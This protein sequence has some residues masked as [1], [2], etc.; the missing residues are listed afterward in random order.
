MININIDENNKVSSNFKTGT[1][2]IFIILIGWLTFLSFF[3][4]NNENTKLSISSFIVTDDTFN[5]NTFLTFENFYSNNDDIELRTLK[6]QINLSVGKV[7]QVNYMFNASIESGNG[8]VLSILNNNNNI[9]ALGVFDNVNNISS[10]S[11][12]YIVNAKTTDINLQFEYKGSTAENFHG[13]II[14]KVIG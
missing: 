3:N 13:N 7:Y 5:D 6:N 4:R 8:K 14:I 1:I 10:V 2:L 11:G 9:N 12:S